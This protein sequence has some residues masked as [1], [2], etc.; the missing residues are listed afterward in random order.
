MFWV[1][2]I[3]IFLIVILRIVGHHKSEKNKEK[4]VIQSFRGPSMLDIIKTD[5]NNTPNSSFKLTH[6][7]YDE[8]KYYTKNLAVKELDT[9]E[10]FTVLVSPSHCKS[11]RFT[12]ENADKADINVLKRIVD[13]AYEIYGA[14]L[15]GKGRFSQEDYDEFSRPTTYYSRT[16]ANVK[17]PFIIDRVENRLE[18]TIHTD[19]LARI[20]SIY[21]VEVWF[22][23]KGINFRE[24]IYSGSFA[25][26]LVPEENNAKDPYAIQVV[27]DEGVL[28]GYFPRGNEHLYSILKE[29]NDQDIFPVA[30]NIKECRD[31]Y[32]DEEFFVGNGCLHT[33]FYKQLDV[34]LLN[35]IAEFE[36]D[37]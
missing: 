7:D 23:I 18:M 1:I 36:D 20:P 34:D 26:R 17:E 8:Y 16:W 2:L 12:T 10:K 25:A 5:L 28:L 32:D 22:R 29:N 31:E 11:Y 33:V 37:L 4:E 27:S 14:D 13:R 9:F 24:G 30:V 6:I 15:L 35:G 19:Q 3:V 21:D